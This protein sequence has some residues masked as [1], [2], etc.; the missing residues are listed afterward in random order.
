MY[1]LTPIRALE[2]D[3][4]HFTQHSA[5]GVAFHYIVRTR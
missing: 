1:S 5:Q 2:N 3:P 4:E